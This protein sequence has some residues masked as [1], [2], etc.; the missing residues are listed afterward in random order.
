M[1]FVGLHKQKSFSEQNSGI[2][3]SLTENKPRTNSSTEGREQNGHIKR[4]IFFTL[5]L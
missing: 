1:K 4:L 5:F 2:N 3:E